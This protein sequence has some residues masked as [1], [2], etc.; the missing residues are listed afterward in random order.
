MS[1]GRPTPPRPAPVMPPADELRRAAL[2][3]LDLE[4][5]RIWAATYLPAEQNTIALADDESLLESMH[6]ARMYDERMPPGT[7][8]A[9]VQWLAA[10]GHAVAQQALELAR[11]EAEKG[12]EE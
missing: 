7:R 10:R 11:A 9:S 8:Y 3:T 1:K 2:L 6:E 12:G 5:M 4:A